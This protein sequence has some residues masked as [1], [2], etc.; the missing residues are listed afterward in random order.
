MVFSSKNLKNDGKDY[1]SDEKI[2]LDHPNNFINYKVGYIQK[3]FN[4]SLEINIGLN[5]SI[6]FHGASRLL[7]NTK[8][9][10]CVEF[11]SIGDKPYLIVDG[12]WFEENEKQYS[13]H[14]H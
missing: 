3:V 6:R 2:E 10:A 12:E 9:I 11:T 13:H 7:P 8:V 14:M 4:N 5:T 1:F